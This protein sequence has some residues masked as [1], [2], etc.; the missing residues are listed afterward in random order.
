MKHSFFSCFASICVAGFVM[1]GMQSCKEDTIL[2]ANLIPVGDTVNTVI[3]PDTFTVLSNTAIDDSLITSTSLVNGAQIQIYH[4]LGVMNDPK[5]GK[6]NAS[7]YMQ[8][9]PPT[10]GYSFPKDPDSAFLILPYSGFTWGD[11][12]NMNILQS[13]NVYEVA[14]TDSLVRDSNY[15]N[16]SRTNINPMPIGTVFNVSYKSLR[17]SVSVNGVN[18]APHLRI[19][20]S[21][22]FVEKVR[23]ESANPGSNSFKTNA[24][25]LRFQRGL[26]VE[27]F[28]TSN[29]ANSLYYIRL[30]GPSDYTRSAI[31]FFYTDKTSNNSDTAKYVMFNFDPTVNSHY[32]R[33]TRTFSG[34]AAQLQS[35]PNATDS[36]FVL[37]N[38]PGS[39]LDLK[40]PFI[41]NLPR[42]PIIKAEL[43]ITQ[44]AVAG[45]DTGKYFPPARLF[46]VGVNADGGTYTILD[47][48]PVSSIEPLL[49][50]DGTRR[51]VSINGKDYH[52]FVLNIPREVQRAIV[53]QRDALHLR[54]NGT[55]TFPGAYRLIGGGS[56]HSDPNA[57][58]KLRI[59]Y[60]KI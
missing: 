49:F 14:T 15:Y 20:L 51:K 56:E 27:K 43:V 38:E 42:Q 7:F 48:L 58:I 30:N 9:L 12:S 28:D 45:D 47:R 10:L 13:F 54:I 18:T 53:E 55:V 32:N 24:D 40:F 3:V 26:Y 37:Q 57:R 2:N 21:Q 25:F 31:Q 35:S 29:G 46:P 33:I 39:T 36:I 23:N 19:R 52:Q 1:L 5:A 34:L 16:F 59:V 11:T 4:A 50:M 60:S 6:T 17:D 44:V 8:V 41:K 22:A